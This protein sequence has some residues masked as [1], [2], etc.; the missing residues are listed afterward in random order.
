MDRLPAV[1]IRP[2]NKAPPLGKR[3]EAEASIVGHI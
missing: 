2:I 3:S 1:P